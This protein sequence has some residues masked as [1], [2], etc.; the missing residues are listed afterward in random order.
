[1]TTM[2]DQNPDVIDLNAHMDISPVHNA[3]ATWLDA[4]AHPP[5]KMGL[6]MILLLCWVLVGLCLSAM[7]TAPL[8][9]PHWFSRL[10]SSIAVFPDSATLTYSFQVPI[11]LWLSAVFGR[12][13]ACIAVALYLALGL[14]G[15]PVFAN[16]GG[17]T[18]VFE[19][20]I[21]YLAG[22]LFCPMLMSN[23]I[24]QGFRNS[25]NLASVLLVFV[26]MAVLTGVLTIHILGVVGLI[27]QWSFGLMPL[28]TCR[29]WIV[30]LTLLP[31][32][33]DFAFGYLLVSLTRVFRTLFWLAFY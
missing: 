19:P 27:V 21:G 9:L 8:P 22:L 26:P 3:S 23:T 15:L 25:R 31:V 33:Y 10:F 28:E 18:Y 1:M 6:S 7:V 24:N 17:W 29:Q 2:T 20:G 5:K 11:V 16:G 30:Q 4:T 13:Y 32:F 12:R 14:A